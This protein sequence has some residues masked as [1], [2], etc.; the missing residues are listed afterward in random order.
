[1]AK[2]QALAAPTSKLRNTSG[3]LIS[4][5]TEKKTEN[6]INQDNTILGEGRREE[7]RGTDFKY[8]LRS[9]A[10]YRHLT[11]SS[12]PL[13]LSP[14]ISQYISF[15]KEVRAMQLTIEDR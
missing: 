13:L 14:F 4:P 9:H 7:E 2:T 10:K 8:F 15:F 12:H 1:M 3:L 11:I 5:A 6:K